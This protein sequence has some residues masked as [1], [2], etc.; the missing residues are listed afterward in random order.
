ML[1]NV[2]LG[3]KVVRT[4]KLYVILVPAHH[5]DWSQTLE[6][7]SFSFFGEGQKGAIFLW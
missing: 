7:L 6:D 3:V 2:D 5:F 4:G 1:P